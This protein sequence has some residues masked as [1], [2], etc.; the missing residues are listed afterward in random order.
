MGR[1]LNEH[2]GRCSNCRMV[3]GG[4][5]FGQKDGWKG[6]EQKAAGGRGSKQKADG[7]RGSGQKDGGGRGSGQKDGGGRLR[8]GGRLIAEGWW[9]EAHNRMLVEELRT[10]GWWREGLRTGGRL[11]TEG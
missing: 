5:D 11:I 10:E 1:K 6:S 7:G 4:R 2:G 3:D 8:T 9:R